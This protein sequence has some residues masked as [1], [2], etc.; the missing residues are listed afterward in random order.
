MQQ[1]MYEVRHLL[2]PQTIA[3]VWTV[4]PELLGFCF[5]FLLTFSFR[6]RALD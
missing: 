4:S 3:S 2:P 1:A 5:Y 6:G